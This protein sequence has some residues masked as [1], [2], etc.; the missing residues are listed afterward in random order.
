MDNP[1]TKPNSNSLISSNYDPF[2]I[3]SNQI[4]NNYE[5]QEKLLNIVKN[6]DKLI[7]LLNKFESS[8]DNCPIDVIE[9]TTGLQID[10]N[11]SEVIKT[12]IRLDKDVW[13]DFSD[14]CKNKYSHLNKHDLISKSFLEFI[15]KY[16]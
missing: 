3:N 9:V 16:H 14:L 5:I 10:F 7:H 2:I 11:K 13:N 15:D 6:Y 1:S 12:T 8:E 4:F